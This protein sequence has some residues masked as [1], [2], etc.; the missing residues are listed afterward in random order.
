MIFLVSILL[1][2]VSCV[3]I[4]F[5]S[6]FFGI[7]DSPDGIK[8]VHKGNIALGGGLC[9][10]IPIL[11]IH[12]IFPEALEMLSL[13]QKMIFSISFFILILG[14]IDD[15]RPLAVSLRLIIQILVSWGVIIATDLYVRDLGDLIGTGSLYIGELGIPLTIFMVV[16]VTNAFNMLDGMDGLVS[17]VSLSAFISFYYLSSFYNSS[18]TGFIIFSCILST[19]ILFNLGLFSKKWKIF[20]GDSGSMWLGF[21]IAWILID[22]SEGPNQI[23]EPVAA[24]WIVLLPLID[25]L[26]TFVIRKREGKPIFSGD[27]S[28]IH[29]ILLDAGLAKWKV[30]LIFISII[31]FT[32]GFGIYLLINDV[33]ES[34][35]FYSFLTVWFFYHLILKYPLSKNS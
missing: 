8:K 3:S 4:I 29:H 32:T 11:L 1:T 35:I 18:E 34:Y 2:A 25:A 5:I 16:G 13:N 19:F 20:L 14:L 7:V 24:L 21:L 23:I 22:L 6:N 10:F 17:F 31:A 33:R 28:H 30:L 12:Y 27:R 26:S 15:I 9:I